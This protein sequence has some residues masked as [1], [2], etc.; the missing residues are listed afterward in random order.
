ML[1]TL[2]WILVLPLPGVE[3]VS[4][5]ALGQDGSLEFAIPYLFLVQ[6]GWQVREEIRH[7]IP[8]QALPQNS[9]SFGVCCVYLENLLGDVQINGRNRHGS[10]SPDCGEA[11]RFPQGP[12]WVHSI[13]SGADHFQR[14]SGIASRTAMLRPI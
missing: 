8:L 9:A 7:V 11:Y 12:G 1:G 14:M 4:E 10:P 3:L 2:V 13:R 5:L 6:A